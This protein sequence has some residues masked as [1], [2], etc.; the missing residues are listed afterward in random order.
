[1][2]SV[3][4]GPPEKPMNISILA[5]SHSSI[6]IGWKA[7]L[8]GGSEQHFKILYREKGKIKYQASH[9]SITGLKTGQSINYTIHELY[10][11]TEYEVIVVAIN[12]YRN[13]SQSKAAA[14]FVTTEGRISI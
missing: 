5:K 7:G 6:T 4:L 3:I 2:L 8:N 11:K 9:D 1:M 13:Q 10:A 14:Q 12:Q